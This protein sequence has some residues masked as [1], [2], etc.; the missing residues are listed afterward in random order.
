[1]LSVLRKRLK[2]GINRAGKAV[3]TNVY[4]MDVA[5]HVCSYFALC[6]LTAGQP[7]ERQISL[8]ESCAP[9]FKQVVFD[10]PR[11]SS[12]RVHF[13]MKSATDVG[14][15]GAFCPRPETAHK[16][17]EIADTIF[18]RVLV[19]MPPGTIFSTSLQDVQ[20]IAS[21][22]R[23]KARDYQAR[24]FSGHI[25]V[26]LSGVFGWIAYGVFREWRLRREARNLISIPKQAQHPA[27]SYDIYCLMLFRGAKGGRNDPPDFA[28][29]PSAERTW[30][31]RILRGSVE[32]H[33]Q[34]P[35]RR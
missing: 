29:S 7:A 17:F 34:R 18:S 31:G 20:P 16:G 11:F 33:G 5:P 1:M 23:N 26:A 28:F 27:T 21:R 24:I 30:R 6:H 32:R 4:Y 12:K 19:S 9:R 14:L 8:I 25:W 22:E 13:L 10:S 3:A 15:T 2:Y 35:G